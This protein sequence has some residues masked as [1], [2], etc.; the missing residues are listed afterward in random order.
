[1]NRK[2]GFTNAVVAYLSYVLKATQIRFDYME[3]RKNLEKLEQTLSSNE[4]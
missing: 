3:A 4:Q 1:M 2:T